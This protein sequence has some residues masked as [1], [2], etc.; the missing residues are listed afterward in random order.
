M[1]K[2]YRVY[3]T[4]GEK[5]GQEVARFEY[6]DDAINFARQFS[7]DHRKEFDPVCGGVMIVNEETGK[8]LMDW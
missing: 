5:D 4:G 6:E 3:W 8:E 7:D 1:K 2:I